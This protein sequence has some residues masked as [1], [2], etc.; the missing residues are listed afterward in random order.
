MTSNTTQHKTATE[1]DTETEKTD[2]ETETYLAA[3]EEGKSNY[4][5]GWNK[6]TNKQ[7]KKT[8]TL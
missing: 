7:T 1:T 5:G 2:T 4:E 3:A 6:Q 8:C